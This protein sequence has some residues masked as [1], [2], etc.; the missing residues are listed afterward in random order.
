MPPSELARFFE[1]MQPFL[2]RKHSVES[3]VGALGPSPS[4]NA[5]LALYPEFIRRQKRNILDSFFSATRAACDAARPG[6]W[7]TLAESFVQETAPTHWEPNHYAEVFLKFLTKRQSEDP[8]MRAYFVELAEYAWTRFAAMIARHPE[9]LDP[10]VD[11][12]IFVRQYSIDVESYSHAAEASPPVTSGTGVSE[13][14]EIPCTLLICR[15]RISH[16]LTIVRPSLAALIA[17]RKREVPEGMLTLPAG[18]TPEA[19]DAEDAALVVLGA[20]AAR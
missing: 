20:L 4:G 9:G 14:I 18:L 15:S 12:A 7:N 11:T 13:P 1:R 17:L 3:L 10:G 8:S 16:R 19:I 2:E 5:R 6:L